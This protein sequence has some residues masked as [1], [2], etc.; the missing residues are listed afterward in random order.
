MYVVAGMQ[1]AVFRTRSG[2]LFATQPRCPHKS[3][4]LADGIVGGSSIVCPLHS[5]KF[6]LVTGA[7]VGNGCAALTTYPVTLGKTGDM[8]ISVTP[9]MPIAEDTVTS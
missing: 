1:I 4:P 5:F 7:P 3:G 8:L 6:D 2:E 9:H